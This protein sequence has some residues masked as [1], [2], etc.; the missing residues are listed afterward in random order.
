MRSKQSLVLIAAVMATIGLVRCS[1][2]K[3]DMLK[4]SGDANDNNSSAN[5]SNSSNGPVSAS[6]VSDSDTSSVSASSVTPA[7]TTAFTSFQ[8]NGSFPIANMSQVNNLVANNFKVTIHVNKSDAY[9]SDNW[10]NVTLSVEPNMFDNKLYLVLSSNVPNRTALMN[11]VTQI[12]F[13]FDANSSMTT[14]AAGDLQ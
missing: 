1:P 8:Q 4:V 5:S 7:Q 14:V 9:V 11:A 2:V 13:A 3:S 10:K 6:V 12:D